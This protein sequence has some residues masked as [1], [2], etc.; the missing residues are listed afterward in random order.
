MLLFCIGPNLD[1]DVVY[2]FNITVSVVTIFY[3][4]YITA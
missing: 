4:V 1:N 2:A 3:F